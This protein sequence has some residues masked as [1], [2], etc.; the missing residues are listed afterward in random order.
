MKQVI[1]ETKGRAREFNELAINLFTGCGHQCIYC[2]GA[3]VTHQTKDDFEH[4]PRIRATVLD[5]LHSAKEWAAKGETRRV[6]LCFVTDPYQPIEQETQLTRKCIMALHECGLNVI[7]L[8]K[9]GHRSMRDFDL[10]TPKDAYA[11]TLTCLSETQSKI[12]EPN[13]AIPLERIV[14]L[15]EAH[16]RGIETWVS[17]EPVIYPEVTKELLLL[18]HEW[19]GHYKVGTMNY[20]PQGKTVNWREF[21]WSMKGLMD[22]MGVKYYFKKDLIKEMGML[23]GNFQQTFVCS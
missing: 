8:T 1:Y 12:W 23:P 5:V 21:G 4:R 13:A 3:D 9:G 2:Y 16:D 19:V 6:L 17:F 11:T 10:L 22:G 18:T 7:I 14:A 20:H 15:A